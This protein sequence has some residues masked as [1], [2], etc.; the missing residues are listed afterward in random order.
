MIFVP[1][2]HTCPDCVEY[3]EALAAGREA[4]SE[5]A[6]R[7]LVLLPTNEIGHIDAWPRPGLSLLADDDGAGRAQLGLGNDQ[8]AVVQADRWGAV[9][10]IA[11]IPTTRGHGELPSVSALVALAKYIDIQCPECG[12]PS[13]EWLLATPFPLG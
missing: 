7:A 6:A 1:H 2:G 5:W 9:Y 3:A 8:A 10:D 13:K 12:V 4:L 11:V